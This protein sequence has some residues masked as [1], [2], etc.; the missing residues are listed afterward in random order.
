M[1]LIYP[2][3]AVLLLVLSSFSVSA[4]RWTRQKSNTLAWLRGVFFA[5]ENRGW[6]VGGNGVILQTEDGGKNWLK[7]KSPTDDDMRDIFFTDEQ[8]GWILCEKKQ[9]QVKSGEARSYLLKTA[10]GGKNWEKLYFSGGSGNEFITRLIFFNK[11]T[12]F[13]TGEAGS[14]FK[15]NSDGNTFLKQT[16]ET[17]YLLFG[18]AFTNEKNG[19]VVG[20]GKTILLTNDGGA[21]WRTADVLSQ[22]GG[23]IYAVSF[24]TPTLGWAIGEEG[25]ILV[26]LDGGKKWRTQNSN[27]EADLFDLKF[28]SS[29]EGWII[30]DQGTILHTVNSGA[31]WNKTE[32]PVKFRLEKL[33]FIN[34][35]KAW[36]VGFGGT[37]LS[38]EE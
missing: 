17:R 12:A 27:V 35:K 16:L 11:N 31:T 23:K 6:A 24:A 7:I 14:L 4:Q 28:M 30:G 26:T 22:T 34:P 32:S 1:R 15:L 18:G 10:D 25:K 38:L 19:V 8:T 13:A 20:A 37:I 29:I 3:L 21:S 36:A 33:F 9:F 5:N 2:V